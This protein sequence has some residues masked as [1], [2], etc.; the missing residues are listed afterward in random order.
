[1]N[2]IHHRIWFGS[3]LPES[4][5]DNVLRFKS[6]N[7]RY[8][9]HLW[10]DCSTTTS[11]EQ[12]QFEDFCKK[13]NLSLHL[14]R[15]HKE[16]VNSDL[17]NEELDKA[18]A[19]AH[20]SRVH[21]ARAS[22]LA[23]VAIVLAMGGLYLDTDT[24][25]LSSLPILVSP[26]NLV[27]KLPVL[28]D[29]TLRDTS[30]EFLIAYIDFI[31][32]EPHNPILKCAAEVT[33]LDYQT[34]HHSQHV[35]WEQSSSAHIHLWT[36]VRLT[37]SSI[38]FAL[39]YQVAQGNLN[40]LVSEGPGFINESL[41]LH[42]THD[43]SWLTECTLGDFIPSAEALSM[44]A[45]REEIDTIREQRYLGDLPRLPCPKTE[46]LSD[47]SMLRAPVFETPIDSGTM[48]QFLQARI[49][50]IMPSLANPMFDR[51]FC[52]EPM[53]IPRIQ[54][55]QPE[56][57]V[58]RIMDSLFNQKCVELLSNYLKTSSRNRFLHFFTNHPPLFRTLEEL[59]AELKTNPFI[60]RSDTITRLNRILSD[61]PKPQ[62]RSLEQ[63]ILTL[64][65]LFNGEEPV[66]AAA[67]APCY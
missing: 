56:L 40:I 59:V 38:R 19:N 43:K 8:E 15:Q 37:G 62:Q 28:S 14:I 11:E 1:M 17:I 46:S 36:T 22:D 50:P 35:L 3:F 52:F 12:Q 44:D 13:N 32:A 23:R 33:R 24:T 64:N 57:D 49:P 67:S 41:F 51:H 2:S 21:Y 16:L 53:S 60:H 55:V 7:P 4:Y 31:A 47:L 30:R 26:T 25:S 18:L 29:C 63:V 34:Y 20:I 66:E 61:T 65:P 9:I 54:P 48:S 6:H 10:S 58:H 5:Q 42:S 45:F 27:L 39:N